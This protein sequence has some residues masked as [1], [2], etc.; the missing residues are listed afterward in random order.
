MHDLPSQTLLQQSAARPKSGE[1]LE[2]FGKQASAMYR[3]GGCS[4]NDAVVET[5]K[6]AGLSP[7]QV[8]R[9][10]E[11]ANTDAYIKEF[12]KKGATHKYIAFQGGP[13]NP[14]EVL[15]DLNDGGGGT[16]FDDGSDDYSHGPMH[17]SS[18]VLLD[19]NRRTMEK[20]ASVRAAPISRTEQAFEQMWKVDEKPLPYAEPLQDA[21]EMQD[22]LAAADDQLR[23]ELNTT[24]VLFAQATE[25]LYQLVKQASEVAPLGHVLQVWE[26]VVPGPGFVK[27]AFSLIGPRLVREEVFPSL[28]SMGSS[29]EK[30]ASRRPYVNTDHPLVSTF[31]AYCGALE[32]LAHLR[33]ARKEVTKEL[34]YLNGFLK[35]AA[36][37]AIGRAA[38]KAWGVAGE[39]GEKAAPYA[40]AAAGETAGK[41]MKY[42]PQAA[43][44]GGTGLVGLEAYDRGVK[45]GPLGR[46]AEFAKSRIP[47]T[48]HYY[49]RQMALAQNPG[50]F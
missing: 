37:G 18:Q 35:E 28:D 45:H 2:V 16:I 31:A 8:K 38:K 12:E 33:E 17:K 27:A 46:V 42:A 48:Q 32:K 10:V 3:C 44:V 29:L 7:E 11:F 1:E 26:E 49:M 24:E 40:E 9:V 4:L 50:L 20:V 34:N 15:K 14:S 39:L 41:V 30:T 6:K 19:R 5:V 23:H 13:A 36:G 47:G 25:D 21:F 43:L 22:K